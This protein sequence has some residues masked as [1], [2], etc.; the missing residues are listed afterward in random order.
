MSAEDNGH[1]LIFVTGGVDNMFAPGRL[2]SCSMRLGPVTECWFRLASS[3]LLCARSGNSCGGL[4]LGGIT[5]LTDMLTKE[6]FG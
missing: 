3:S 4:K 2:K 5:L 1:S 6:L